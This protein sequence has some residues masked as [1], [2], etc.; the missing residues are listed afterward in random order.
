MPAE[1]RPIQESEVVNYLRTVQHAFGEDYTQAYD[2]SAREVLEPDRSWGA[3][4]SGEVVGCASSYTS[5]LTLPG[6][7]SPAAGVC[8]VG[9]LPTHRRRGLLTGLMG[10]VLGQ[11]RERGEPLA[12][13]FA[14]ESQIYSRFGF[15]P[16][17]HDSR[18]TLDTQTTRLRDDLPRPAG[19][20]RFMDNAKALEV[21]PA[22]YESVRR[23]VPGHMHLSSGWWRRLL[24]HAEAHAGFGVQRIAVYEEGGVPGGFAVF[25][26]RGDWSGHVA[27]GTVLVESLVCATP[28]AE[29]ALWGLLCSID[30]FPLVRAAFR[31]APEPLQMLLADGRQLTPTVVDNLWLRILDV[32]GA[33]AARTYPVESVLTLELQDDL[34]A[35]NSGRWL[36]EAGP[37]GVAV[38]RTD[39]IPDV[40]TD[41]STLAT[42]LL[43]SG[44]VDPPRIGGSLTGDKRSLATL[45]ALFSWPVT[46]LCPF[47]F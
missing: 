30:L 28:D 23:S 36:L 7:T 25:R 31:P 37:D 41:V 1:I 46:A 47:L 24:V 44:R 42:F 39:R 14:S 29:T 22:V 27:R 17:A 21:L 32:P 20:V 13:L 8:Q 40:T 12:A 16:A 9:V 6:T 11:A 35:E 2:A 33:L 3:F 10:H 4:D 43:G 38:T 15:G 26:Q 45:Q 18:W 34:V 19:T 5:T